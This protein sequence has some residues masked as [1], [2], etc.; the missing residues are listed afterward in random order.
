MNE[1]EKVCRVIE[2]CEGY[3]IGALS[4]AVVDD[5][6]MLDISLRWGPEKPDMTIS[7]REVTYFEMGRDAG[8]PAGPLCE[9]QASV[10]LPT[11]AAW[12]E[13]LHFDRVR[14]WIDRP[15]IWIRAA[16]PVQ[17]SVLASTAVVLKE[18]Q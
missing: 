6:D 7:L 14:K 8:V 11:G 1:L 17:L 5:G 15:L 4:M 16:G 18:V 2:S 10:L 9:L 3:S 12:P 13:G